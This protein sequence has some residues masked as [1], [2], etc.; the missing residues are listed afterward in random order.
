MSNDEMLNVVYHK[1][2][3]EML[4]VYSALQRR[5]VQND[6]ISFWAER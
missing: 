3:E 1:Y 5:K 4:R 6:Y 2:T